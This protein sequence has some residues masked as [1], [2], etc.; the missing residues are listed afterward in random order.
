MEQGMIKFTVSHDIREQMKPHHRLIQGAIATI[1]NKSMGV[2]VEAPHALSRKE[3][4]VIVNGREITIKSDYLLDE[5]K[6][7]GM[8]KPRRLTKPS[9]TCKHFGKPKD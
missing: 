7:T 2:S 1:A 9:M 6:S 3:S 4:G 5:E 8:D